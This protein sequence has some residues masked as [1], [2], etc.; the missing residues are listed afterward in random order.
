MKWLFGL[1][2]IQSFRSFPAL[3]SNALDLN[4]KEKLQHSFTTQAPAQFLSLIYY[5]SFLTIER[6]MT[7]ILFKGLKTTLL[8]EKIEDHSACHRKKG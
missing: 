6:M 7:Y 1:I 8:V 2:A 4:G 5:D 3:K